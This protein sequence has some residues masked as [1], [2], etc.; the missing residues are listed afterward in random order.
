[1]SLRVK[2]AL[3]L[4]AI[5][6]VTI[7]VAW[8]VT[9]RTVI[10]PFT[11]A[12][13]DT[14]LDEVVYIAER[15]E[16][17][18]KPEELSR[19]LNLDVRVLPRPPPFMR[20][21]PPGH[22]PPIDEQDPDDLG[23]PGRRGPKHRCITEPRGR[24]E[25]TLC[26]GRRTPVMVPLREGFLIVRRDL[27]VDAPAQR[28]GQ[29]LLF[30]A[31]A[32]SAASF[33]LAA[34]LTKPL[35][36]TRR[37]LEKIADGDLSHRLPVGGGRELAGV[38][39]AYNAMADRVDALLRTEREL[40]AG[41]SHEL[42]TPLA[43]LRLQLELLRDEAVPEKRLTAMERDLEDVDALIGEVL[44]SSR[45]SLGDRSITREA[46]SLER[47]IDD[48][49]A[50][51]PLPKHTIDVAKDAPATIRGD[52]VRLV[53][54]L[55]NLLQNA[56]KYAPEGTAVHVSITGAKITVADRGPGVPPDEL[57]RLFEPFYRGSSARAGNKGGLGLGLMFTRQVVVLHGGTIDAQ[58][59][60]EGGLE[61]T[62][63][64]PTAPA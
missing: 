18:A 60:A 50:K 28:I 9:G 25:L 64:L 19:A 29:L 14:Y 35:E 41:I 16:G 21:P 38:A 31:I 10:Q 63:E 23:P 34:V 15:I 57:P 51:N 56:G 49:I 7:F 20:P 52:H 61:I 13:L 30:I 42:R 17:G 62:L 37:A 47:V 58:N 24:F 4:A 8:I 27:D 45:L 32:V 22:E 48:A 11:R 53:R 44:E 3:L 33:A 46:V 40:L 39:T 59:R 1:M 5:V 55:G 36:T 2:L 12:V 54:A 43:R 6:G 26:R